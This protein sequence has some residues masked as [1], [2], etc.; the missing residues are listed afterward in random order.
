MFSG[1]LVLRFLVMADGV[2]PTKKKKKKKMMEAI[3]NFP[4]LT[5]IMSVK[6]WFELA[7]Q[8]VYAFSQAEIK[9]S[10]QDLPQT[11]DQKFY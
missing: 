8:V 10:F 11:K 7:N 9:V 1:F 5:N 2:K 3:L 4:T 6:S